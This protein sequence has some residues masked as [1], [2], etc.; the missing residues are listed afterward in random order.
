MGKRG[1]SPPVVRL[2]LVENNLPDYDKDELQ[3]E[4]ELVAKSE[5][6]FVSAQVARKEINKLTN[7][8]KQIS[9]KDPDFKKKS[10]EIEAKIVAQQGVAEMSCRL[11]HLGCVP[12]KDNKK[13]VIPKSI[14]NEINT[15]NGTKID[16]EELVT[17]EGGEHTVAYIP[18]W[19][20]LKNDKPVIMFY[21][22]TFEPAMPRLA[23]GLDGDP[24]NKSGTTIGVGVDLGQ[25][26]AGE[27]LRKMKKWNKGEHAISE[28]ELNALHEKITPYFQLVGGDACKFLR[29]H[30]LNLDERQTNFLDKISQDDALERTMLLYKNRT[31]HINA[32]DFHDLTA[33]QQTS[34]LSNTY[35]YGKPSPL[36]LRAIVQE[37]RSLI[38]DI[39]EREYLFDSMPSD[40]K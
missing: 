32:K 22:E 13:I 33:E 15:R 39:R 26:K 28:A 14:G 31:Q 38:P 7:E 1:S 10:R 17:L 20:Y 11:K 37:K 35:Q 30:P 21:P 16:F 5:A 34:L 4:R 23:G 12:S 27:F 18:W 29:E 36:L 3:K 24:S 25:F 2:A 6:C 9:K 8:K 40:K 19:P